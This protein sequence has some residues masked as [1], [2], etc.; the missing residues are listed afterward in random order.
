M[1]DARHAL[2]EDPRRG[3]VLGRRVHA[4]GHHAKS[5]S[6][7]ALFDPEI[8]DGAEVGVESRSRPFRFQVV[9]VGA[10]VDDVAQRQGP[11]V[12]RGL[13]SKPATAGQVQAHPRVEQHVVGERRFDHSHLQA[14]RFSPKNPS[15]SQES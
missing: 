14:R 7:A 4:L 3:R 13:V 12:R 11:G 2:L 8:K 6:L 15:R 1:H 5:H 10:K 9:P